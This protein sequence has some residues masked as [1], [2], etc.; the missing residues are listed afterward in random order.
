MAERSQAEFSGSRAPGVKE[1]AARARVSVGTV[2]NVLNHRA[3]VREPTRRRVERAIAELGFVVNEPA[4]LLRAGRSRVLAYVML[5]V[6]NPFFTDVAQGMETAADEAG[7]SLYL[8]NSDN[9]VARERR[10]VQ[11]LHEQRVQG[12]LITPNDPDDEAIASLAAQSTP[13]VIVDRVP[14]SNDLCSVAVDDAMGGR[15]AAQHLL[16]LGHCRLAFVGAPGHVGQARS[17]RQGVCEVLDAD[18]RGTRLIDVPTAALTVEDGRRAGEL[19]A[20]LPASER[21][22]AAFC[23]ND[24]L[25]LGLLQ[26]TMALGIEVPDDL[27]I[28][29]YDDIDLAAAA[30]VPLTSVRQPRWAIGRRATELLIDEGTN[31][32]HRHERVL[33]EPELVAR[34]S[35]QRFSPS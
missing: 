26:S 20:R 17:R 31:Y 2:S 32:E 22:S 3:S 21:P 19:I 7:L 25:A 15:L 30:A 8:C 34:A 28:V 33:F 1:V 11:R 24:L 9:D 23:A 4:R 35:T 18:R 27:A 6:T 12:V 5:D 29:G 10:Y 16:D 14:R 13:V